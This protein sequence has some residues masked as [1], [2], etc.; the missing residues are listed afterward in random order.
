[1]HERSSSGVNVERRRLLYLSAAAVAQLWGITRGRSVFASDISGRPQLSWDSLLRT[2]SSMADAIVRDRYADEET[3]LEELGSLIGQSTD[4]PSPLFSKQEDVA[5]VSMSEKVPLVI[6]Q[7]KLASGAVI[8]S[9]DHRNY[10]AI[11]RVV[12]GDI[13]LRSFNIVGAPASARDENVFQVEESGRV[14]LAE[15]EISTLS[16]SRDNIH[17]LRAR[18]RGARFIDFFTFFGSN[19]RSVNLHVDERPTHAYG[20]LYNARW[21]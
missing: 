10:N 2:A 3:Y 8:P 6:V 9:H 15:G 1:M 18:S 16:R 12:D 20:N 14:V 11:L 17:Q 4:T 21:L 5:M 7:Y 19:A 13:E